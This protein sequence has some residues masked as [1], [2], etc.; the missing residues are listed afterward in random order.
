MELKSRMNNL[1]LLFIKLHGRIICEGQ[2]FTPS[3]NLFLGTNK[4]SLL[5]SNYTIPISLKTVG[6][7]YIFMMSTFYVN[8][9]YSLD[10]VT[11]LKKHLGC[12][13]IN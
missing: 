5:F 9:C 1:N 11:A 12:S 10:L 6:T 7:E 13:L 2:C 8:S 3:Q 4:N